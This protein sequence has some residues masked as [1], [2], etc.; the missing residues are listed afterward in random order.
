MFQRIMFTVLISSVLFLT[1]DCNKKMQDQEFIEVYVQIARATERYLGQADSL[2][3]AHTRI[4]AESGFTKEEFDEYRDRYSDEP[5]K[6]LPVWQEIEKR[7]KAP[8]PAKK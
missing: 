2:K 5:E 6:W 4:F 1:A 8:P 3:A 7:L